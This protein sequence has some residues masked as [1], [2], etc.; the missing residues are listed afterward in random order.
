[1]KKILVFLCVILLSG[2]AG[3]KYQ[4]LG[5]SS[6]EARMIVGLAEESRAFFAE[7]DEK[8]A[9]LLDNEGFNEDR[10]PL[11]VKYLEL[12]DSDRTVSLVNEG[13]LKEV[14]FDR[15]KELLKVED[16]KTDRLGEYLKYYPRAGEEVL[17]YLVN[18][19][20]TDDY[21]RI[22]RLAEDPMFVLDDLD[23][24]LEHYEDKESVRELLEYINSKAYLPQYYNEERADV[25][26]YGYYV[27]VN[28][29]YKLDADY[30]PDDLV[31][32]EVGYGRG[33]MRREAYE[34]Y[35]KMQEAAAADGI[36]FYI[37]SPYRSY[38]TQYN[39]YNRYLA[40]D[41][42]AVV[43]TYSARPGNSEHQLGL[44]ADILSAGYDF[45]NFYLAPAAR[46]LEDNAYKYG[47]IFRYPQSKI[48]IT[49]YKYEPWHYRYVGDIAED[50]FKSGVTYDEYFEKYIKER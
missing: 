13:V 25:D 16:V 9:G 2:C 6:E 14:N 43:D 19:D 42:Q 35:K 28:K 32:V 47:F 46:W 8:L 4:K 23:T 18:N 36:Y 17:V 27:L 45:G 21:N 40:N 33:Q 44:A 30:A 49:G 24:Y 37:I 3:Y 38:E 11:Y 5:Y 7:Y 22:V 20:M 26:K 31:N 34:A 41:P 1:M 12:L 15:V 50:V 10:L 29:Y 48:D 39:L